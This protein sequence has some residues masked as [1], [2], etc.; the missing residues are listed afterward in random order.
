MESSEEVVL[1]KQ[2]ESHDLLGNLIQQ[3]HKDA[4]LAGV[5][6]ICDKGISAKELVSK[7]YAFLFQ[8]ITNDFGAYLNFLY[9]VDIPERALKSITEIEPEL[10][11]KKV[12]LMVLQREWQKVWFRNK[13]Q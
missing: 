13:N 4:D 3:I 12:T 11:V 2:I 7:I 6:F 5:S 8:L 10:I 1:L 9:R